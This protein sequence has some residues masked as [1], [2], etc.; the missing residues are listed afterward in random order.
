[1]EVK[2]TNNNNKHSSWNLIFI[3]F[4]N[5]VILQT[6]MY[7]TLP[8]FAQMQHIFNTT[9]N[10]IQLTYSYFMLGVGIYVF[11]YGYINTK[12][13]FRTILLTGNII[14]VIASILSF[15]IRKIEFLF[16]FRVLQ[17]I[18]AG[19]GSLSII[20]AL[21]R[22]NYE[23]TVF[24]KL[25]SYLVSATMVI[26]ILA[27]L[28]GGYL[29]KIFG[30]SGNFIFTI[31]LSTVITVITYLFL[32]NINFKT[33]G[34]SYFKIL[35]SH[36]THRNFMV[37]MIYSIIVSALLNSFNVVAP[38]LLNDIGVS[39][40]W[41]GY[42]L[43]SVSLIFG[44]GSYANSQLVSRFSCR[45]MIQ[46]ALIISTL[47]TLALLIV[48]YVQP[49][50]ALTLIV[51]VWFYAFGAAILYPNVISKG[52]SEIKLHSATSASILGSMQLI[53]IFVATSITA[54]LPEKTAIPYAWFVIILQILLLILIVLFNREYLWR[55]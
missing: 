33:S 25:I 41:L 11:F 36:L 18:G 37:H 55:K 46:I 53:A 8:S 27:P 6:A 26:S 15:L 1:M 14:F 29:Q 49:L 51:P 2:E 32:K 44:V 43:A 17:G 31:I 9:S 45:V 47:A 7:V 5:V 42:I 23:G 54:M 39:A 52:F 24:A 34:E 16:L 21:L 28:I 4:L 12:F 35:K 30:W 50:S 10:N 20:T 22:I 19:S 3:A 13:S 38:F 48:N 40:I